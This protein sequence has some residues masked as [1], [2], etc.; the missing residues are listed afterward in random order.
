MDH[1]LSIFLK[2]AR[3]AALKKFEVS[4]VKKQMIFEANEDFIAYY[5]NEPKENEKFSLDKVSEIYELKNIFIVF[6]SEK[7]HLIIPKN[8][9]TSKTI[10]N[11]AK[12]CNKHILKFED[13]SSQ[14]ILK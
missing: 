13:F 9:I 4:G 8:D 3:I 5:E 12:F 14:T 11:L 6:L 7:I 1:F 10:N 2:K